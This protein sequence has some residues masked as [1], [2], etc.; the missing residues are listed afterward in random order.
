MLLQQACFLQIKAYSSMTHRTAGVGWSWHEM[1]G[2]LVGPL[3]KE[4]ILH[5]K[6]VQLGQVPIMVVRLSVKAI[7]SNCLYLSAFRAAR[8]VPTNISSFWN[9]SQNHGG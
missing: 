6:Y 5:L 1:L 4:E 9:D 2:R 7:V 3:R 8:I